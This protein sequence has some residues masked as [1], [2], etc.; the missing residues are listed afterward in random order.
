MACSEVVASL[1]RLLQCL[2]VQVLLG[3]P[4]V[5]QTPSDAVPIVPR[6]I[7]PTVPS[8]SGSMQLL[9]G[10][11]LHVIKRDVNLVLVPVSVTDAMQRLVTG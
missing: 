1:K 10:T 2:L 4:V 9:G 11:Y 3:I 5:A 8:A 7:F 6:E